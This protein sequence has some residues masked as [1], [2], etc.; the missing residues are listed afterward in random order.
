[1]QWRDKSMVLLVN[2][3][4]HMK[5]NQISCP[6]KPYKYQ[7]IQQPSCTAR[8]WEVKTGD[9]GDSRGQYDQHF[10]QLRVLMKDPVSICN[11][12]SSQGGQHQLY[13]PTLAWR[14]RGISA[15]TS[16]ILPPKC[17]TLWW[18][19]LGT[20]PTLYEPICVQLIELSLS[21]SISL[22]LIRLA[23]TN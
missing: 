7:G 15:V 5:E 1:M 20:P 12:G 17:C 22:Y 19:R 8:A 2:G 10:C 23:Y 14:Q 3:L 13:F 18:R 6:N 21:I 9:P 16:Y 11:L 4:L